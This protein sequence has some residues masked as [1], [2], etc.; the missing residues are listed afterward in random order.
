[1]ERCVRPEMLD[2]GLEVRSALRKERS[3]EAA[4]APSGAPSRGGL[5]TPPFLPGGP[6]VRRTLTR[7]WVMDE[8]AELTTVR[9]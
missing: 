8:P 1:M 3:Q 6:G 9:E 4:P 7:P 5:G 2:S